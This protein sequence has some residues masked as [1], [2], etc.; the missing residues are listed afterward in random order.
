MPAATILI[1]DDESLLRWSLRERMVEEGYT[2][3]EAG[4]V[5]EAM[6]HAADG[7]DLVE[8]MIRLAANQDVEVDFVAGDT[9]RDL[10]GVA[11]LLK[12]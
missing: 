6:Q 11:A 7:I 9:M 5:A 4:T 2:V 10:S 8:S 1:V 3:V 12:F